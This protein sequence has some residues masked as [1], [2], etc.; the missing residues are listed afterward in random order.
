MAELFDF[1]SGFVPVMLAC[2][3]FAYLSRNIPSGIE[4]PAAPAPAA[5]KAQEA[6]T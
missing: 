6:R 1:L 5:P 4:P 2:A 3:A